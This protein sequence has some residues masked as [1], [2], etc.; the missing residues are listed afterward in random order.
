MFCI[1]SYEV[2]PASKRV[3]RENLLYFE[4]NV[5]PLSV[6]SALGCGLWTEWSL[7]PIFGKTPAT[8]TPSIYLYTCITIYTL[9]TVTKLSGS[10]Q[11]VP[12]A[13]LVSSS[14]VEEICYIHYVAFDRV[15]RTKVAY[16]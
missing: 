16:P 4:Y 12:V 13:S 9:L 2:I 1:Q 11:V 8:L 15:Y 6:W 5:R 10:F 7:S 3:V 14:S